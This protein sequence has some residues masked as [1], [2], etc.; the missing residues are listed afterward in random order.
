MLE[1]IVSTCFNLLNVA[2]LL[3]ICWYVYQTRARITLEQAKSHSEA[4]QD[5]VKRAISQS[6]QLF[7]SLTEAAQA[8]K[9]YS[10]TLANHVRRWREYEAS[11]VASWRQEQ[12]ILEKKIYERH[13]KKQQGLV[14]LYAQTH[15]MPSAIQEAQR[16]VTQQFADP[17][18]GARYIDTAI[19]QL[20]CIANKRS[21]P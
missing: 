3:I 8:Q 12:E 15:L 18:K 17:N 5:A 10:H 9:Q 7:G 21:A 4:A 20:L 14:L 6:E 1:T 13:T 2:I 19:K 11:L 16:A